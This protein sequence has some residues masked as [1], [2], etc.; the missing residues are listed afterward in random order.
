MAE[1]ITAIPM[2]SSGR[3]SRRGGDDRDRDQDEG[4]G[5]LTE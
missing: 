4:G 1:R 2:S 5:D 3:R